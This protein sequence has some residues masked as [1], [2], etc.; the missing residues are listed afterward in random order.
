M[1]DQFLNLSMIAMAFPYEQTMGISIDPL[2]QNRFELRVHISM[3]IKH[4]EELLAMKETTTT[5]TRSV[6]AIGTQRRVS[7]YD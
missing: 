7:Q 1:A 5:T 2:S 3:K 6:V 4:T